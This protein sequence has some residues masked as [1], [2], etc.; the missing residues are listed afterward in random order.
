MDIGLKSIRNSANKKKAKDQS[1]DGE[2]GHSAHGSKKTD[3]PFETKPRLARKPSQRSEAPA[4][5]S[6]SMPQMDFQPRGGVTF[7]QN[8]SSDVA[9]VGKGYS[10]ESQQSDPRPSQHAMRAKARRS[11]N[12]KGELTF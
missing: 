9:I 3:P 7:T 10:D 8:R 1:E 12:S 5:S 6:P 4:L 2:N 11:M